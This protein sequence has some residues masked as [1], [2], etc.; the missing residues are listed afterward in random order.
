MENKKQI[1]GLNPLNMSDSDM[2][3]AQEGASKLYRDNQELWNKA[4][5]IVK[6]LGL[7]GLWRG[8]SAS[9]LIVVNA[10]KENN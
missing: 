2:K 1:K 8:S 9:I 7:S 3:F 10:I 5:D 4:Y 6:Q